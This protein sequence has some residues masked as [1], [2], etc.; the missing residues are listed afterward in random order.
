MSPMIIMKNGIAAKTINAIGVF[1]NSAT[2][3]AI[4]ILNAKEP[5]TCSNETNP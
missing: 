2:Y 5:I 1:M 4:G 3:Q